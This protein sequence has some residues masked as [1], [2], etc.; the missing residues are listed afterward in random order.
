M[1]DRRRHG[2]EERASEVSGGQVVTAGVMSH[3]A[4]RLSERSGG[5]EHL[6][7]ACNIDQARRHLAREVVNH[8]RVQAPTSRL[9]ICPTKGIHGDQVVAVSL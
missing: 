5:S 7:A 2:R 9:P 8:G 6:R 4:G 1:A 3:P